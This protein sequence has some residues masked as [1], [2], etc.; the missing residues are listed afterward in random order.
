MTIASW[1][2]EEK[3]NNLWYGNRIVKVGKDLE[4]HQ[5][6]LSTRHHHAC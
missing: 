3:V 5:V 1:A 2:V 6:Q 4:D